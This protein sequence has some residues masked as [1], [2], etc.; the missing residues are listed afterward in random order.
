MFEIAQNVSERN[1]ETTQ[2][3]AWITASLSGFSKPPPFEECFPPKSP[4]KKSMVTDLE[5]MFRSVGG[6]VKRAA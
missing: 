4:S 1:R 2:Y 5:A 3:L 6:D